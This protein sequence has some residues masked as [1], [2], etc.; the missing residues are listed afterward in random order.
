MQVAV[1]VPSRNAPRDF[2]LLLRLLSSL[3]ESDFPSQY[4][5][6]LTVG[7]TADSRIQ[8][9]E[10]AIKTGC[11]HILVSDDDCAVPAKWWNDAVRVADKEGYA[12]P[13]I[14]GNL[15]GFILFT[16]KYL[17]DNQIRNSRFAGCTANIELNIRHDK[18]IESYIPEKQMEE[19]KR[20][21]GKFMDDQGKTENPNVNN[22]SRT[23]L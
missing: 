7:G 22:N 21:V 19:V 10:Q 12:A 1:V 3:E 2:M 8:G 11:S 14:N 23:S 15:D 4:T 6:I 16:W 13:S 17:V 5:L 9:I 20:L 18:E